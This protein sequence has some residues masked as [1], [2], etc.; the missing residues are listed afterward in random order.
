MKEMFRFKRLCEEVRNVVMSLNERHHNLHIFH[1]FADKEVSAHH[2]L[3]AALV[4]WIV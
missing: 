1:A 3:D 2:V 4:L